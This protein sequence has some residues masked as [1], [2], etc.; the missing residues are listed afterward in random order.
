MSDPDDARARGH[1]PEL[2]QAAR[3]GLATMV[4]AGASALL[5]FVLSIVLAR[6]LGSYGSG[7][8]YQAIAVFMI[9]LSLTRLGMDTTA[10]WLL[11][12]LMSQDRHLVRPAVHGILVPALVAPSVVVLAWYVGAPW[13]ADND[14]IGAID[15]VAV[16]LPA[17]AVMTVA[18]AATR[19]FG[20][21][22]P[23]NLVG[24]VLVPGLRPLLIVG[25]VALGATVAG[26]ALGWAAPWAVGMV[27]GLWVLWVQMRRTLGP[28]TGPLLPDRDLAGRIAGYGLPRVL[29]AALDQAL[30]WLDVLLVGLIAGPAAA[31]IYGAASRFIRGG[32]VVST[33][34]R[35]VVAPRFSALL[36][37]RRLEDVARLYVTTSGWILL[38]GAPAYLV[39]A[40]YGPTV[41]SWLGED[42]TDGVTALA[43]LSLGTLVVL[44]AGNIQSLLLMSG[45]SG[46]SALNKA[47]VVAFNAVANL[48]LV[49]IYGIN[50]AAVAWTVSMVL[51]TALAAW[52]VARTE[53]I[54]P[55]AGS[56]LRV[57]AAVLLTVGLPGFL[58]ARFL[59]QGLVPLVVSI[60]AGGLLLAGYA[61]LDRRRLRLRELRTVRRRPGPPL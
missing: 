47:L 59:G 11:P 18:L 32:L 50:G 20:G 39:L 26:S 56:I 42:F 27:V 8:V 34:F 30:V 31:G 23:F 49:P 1:D 46:V 40:N 21:V 16:F 4:G 54:S 29:A 3:G 52:W 2:A 19:A 61:W 24:N 33:A 45:R 13:R 17:A 44:A 35:I 25:S 41:L 58:L 51:D 55:A 48:I 5:G 6:A 36:A 12:R 38:L 9:A 10:V 22:V 60:L 14:V 37:Q 7:V 43:I 53:G 57:L 15:A 28:R